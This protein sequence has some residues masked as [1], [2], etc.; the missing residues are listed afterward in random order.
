MISSEEIIGKKKKKRR[1]KEEKE[2]EEE[3]EVVVVVVVVVV[4]LGTHRISRVYYQR[5]GRLSM[6]GWRR[7][8]HSV[9][10][11]EIRLNSR[12]LVF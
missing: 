12:T 3:E 1:K 6:Q 10:T 8:A 4:V 5:V 11:L 2:V 9:R 7:S